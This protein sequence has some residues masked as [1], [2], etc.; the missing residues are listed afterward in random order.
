MT[1]GRDGEFHPVVWFVEAANSDIQWME[2]R[3]IPLVQ[4]LAGINVPGGIKSNYPDRLPA[5]FTPGLV[6]R[7]Q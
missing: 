5:G 4:A 7:R 2:P 1:R 3:D 6:R